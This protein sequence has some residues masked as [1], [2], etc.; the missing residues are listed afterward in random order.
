MPV[1]QPATPWA[2]LHPER[3]RSLT[4]L[5]SGVG[6]RGFFEAEMKTTEKENEPE[7]QHPQ[8]EVS[9]RGTFQRR[10]AEERGPEGGVE[11]Q[12]NGKSA[13]SEPV[14]S[15]SARRCLILFSR[16]HQKLPEAEILGPFSCLPR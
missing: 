4:L 13:S 6:G 10:P 16:R 3:E 1:L 12:R 7:T 9:R 8:P 5:S 11:T 2:H 14:V 15:L